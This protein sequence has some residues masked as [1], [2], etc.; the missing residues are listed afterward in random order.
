MCA[1]VVAVAA[2]AVALLA[3][4]TAE[5]HGYTTSPI[6]RAYWCQRGQVA[7]CGP[8]QY[9]PQSIEGPKGFPQAG[10]ADGHIC[11]AG[12]DR[13]STVDEP[14]TPSGDR[15]PTT[16]LSS[17]NPFTFSWYFTARHKTTSFVY[18]LTKPDWNAD[19]PLTRADLDL[20][21]PFSIDY[22]GQLPPRTVEHTVNNLPDR[23]GHQLF[24]AVWNIADT[25]NAFYQ[26]ADVF[27]Q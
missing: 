21:N 15:W 9:E 25:G 10:P 22:G 2:S 17:E 5:A 20:S 4:V 16:T 8:V 13:F 11:S 18:Y 27:F 12:I 24:L 6:S 19:E 1:L 14:L 23:S 26:C 7:D 3:P